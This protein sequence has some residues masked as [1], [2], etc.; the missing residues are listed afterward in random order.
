VTVAP[1]AERPDAN[2]RTGW[3]RYAPGGPGGAIIAV[4]LLVSTIAGVLMLRPSPE[5]LSEPVDVPVRIEAT[6][7]SAGG[8]QAAIPDIPTLAG[9]ADFVVRGVARDDA[10]FRVTHVLANHTNAAV[11]T[12]TIQLKHAL[13]TGAEVILFLSSRDSPNSRTYNADVRLFGLTSPAGGLW[14]VSGGRVSPPDAA[15]SDWSIAEFGDI[16]KKAPNPRDA[17]VALLRQYG[18]S[19]AAPDAVGYVRLG[20]NVPPGSPEEQASIDIGL[21]PSATSGPGVVRIAWLASVRG[22]PGVSAYVLVSGKQ[23][24]A[25]WVVVDATGTVYSL[26]QRAEAFGA[27]R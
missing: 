6:P 12:I 3:R 8:P 1:P 20:E 21:Q 27:A 19:P 5:Q 15:S 22:E 18:F 4:V 25:A 17:A 14:S 7:A 10:R 26:K 24:V 16:V 9:V 13:P 2:P 11:N 23:V